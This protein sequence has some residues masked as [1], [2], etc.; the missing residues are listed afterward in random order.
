MV[1]P[2]IWAEDGVLRRRR[3]DKVDV[4]LVPA[5]RKWKK[6][7][8][9]YKN[10]LAENKSIQEILDENF[11]EL[12]AAL[13]IPADTPDLQQL[14]ATQSREYRAILETD[15]FEQ[16]ESNM[17][18]KL[19]ML[20]F[21]LPV[22]PLRLPFDNLREYMD[23]RESEASRYD[24]KPPLHFLTAHKHRNWGKDSLRGK[25]LLGYLLCISLPY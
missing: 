1:V 13:I 25:L 14:Q 24:V 20:E 5:H 9:Y 8:G 4:A 21:G 6:T 19:T 17:A 10:Q 3:E 22:E 11:S 18:L 7:Y 15:D 23:D 16:V 12:Q 2:P